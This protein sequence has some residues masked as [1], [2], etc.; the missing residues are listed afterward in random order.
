MKA[1]WQ[2]GMEWMITGF[3][4]YPEAFKRGSSRELLKIL[5]SNQFTLHVFFCDFNEITCSSKKR[6]GTSRPY[7]QME[8]F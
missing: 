6:G 7:K 4:G 2:G 1:D 5:S 8:I 3:Y